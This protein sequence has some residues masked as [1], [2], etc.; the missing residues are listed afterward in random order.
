MTNSRQHFGRLGIVGGV[1]CVVSVWLVVSAN[2]AEPF[3]RRPGHGIREAGLPGLESLLDPFGES[4]FDRWEREWDLQRR[5]QEEEERLRKWDEDLRRQTEQM[6]R[7]LQAMEAENQRRLAQLERWSR[8]TEERLAREA[9]RW[10]EQQRREQDRIGREH[11]FSPAH[12]TRRYDRDG[13]GA[14]GVYEPDG[15]GTLRLGEMRGGG[16]SI[17]PGGRHQERLYLEL[18]GPADWI[19]D[20]L[21]SHRELAKRAEEAM[22]QAEREAKE[23]AAREKLLRDTYRWF[24][25]QQEQWR[26]EQDR[27]AERDRKA[28]EQ[29][30]KDAWGTNELLKD[31]G[32]QLRRD[33]FPSK[34]HDFP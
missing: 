1:A 16:M 3:G 28:E 20:E 15:G 8:E 18:N 32:R 7:N 14:F 22:Q 33:L 19:R 17:L 34:K 31:M 25:K 29:R 5:Q 11:L 12:R 30:I 4:A 6:E 21:A 13:W 26:K 27:Q 10:E 9:A 2:A 24:E 23:Q